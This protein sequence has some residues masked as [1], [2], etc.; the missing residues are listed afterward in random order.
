MHT[1]I[2]KL[3][4]SATFDVDYGSV[5]IKSLSENFKNINIESSYTN[6]KIGVNSSSS[7]NIKA[8]LGYGNLKYGDGF[9]FSKEIVKNSSKYYEG[10]YNSPNSNSNITLKTSYGNISLSN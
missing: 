4:G 9:T 7:F 3:N 10:Y 2:G 1:S 5:K 8:N 6:I